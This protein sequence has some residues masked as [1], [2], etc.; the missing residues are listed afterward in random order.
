MLTKRFSLLVSLVLLLGVS[1]AALAQE[2]AGAK[3]SPAN[4]KWSAKYEVGDALIK[5]GTPV[6][7]TLPDAQSLVWQL[8]KG[9]PNTIPLNTITGVTY[10]T[11]AHHR[12]ASG[13]ALAAFSPLGGIML[14]S[15]KATK[16]FVTIGFEQNGEKKDVAFELAKN[17]YTSFL[18]EM[19]K[20]TGKPWKDLAAERKQTE[21]EIQKQ[22]N[23]KVAIKLDHMMR[24]SETDLKPGDYQIVVLERP[25]N[26]AEVYFFAGKKVNPEKSLAMAKVE[27]L[28]Q[29]NDVKSAQV[30]HKEDDKLASVTEIRLPTKTLRVM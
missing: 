17:D 13:A 15:S 5:R 24:V 1:L 29:A 12:T 14:M 7:L 25:E 21:A 16:H 26:K 23:N 2:K 27:I 10:D 4:T 11:R 18:Q 28:S 8:E 22:Q 9:S 30:I 6:Y 20:M 3:G 19:Q